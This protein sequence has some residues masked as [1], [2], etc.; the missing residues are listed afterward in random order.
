M[1]E[2]EVFLLAS[3]T[4]LISAYHI[5]TAYIVQNMNS[6]YITF[7]NNIIK[8]IIKLRIRTH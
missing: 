8:K 5:H 4:V 6:L 1:N 2:Y 7:D 3:S